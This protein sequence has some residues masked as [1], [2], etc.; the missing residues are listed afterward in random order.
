M[1][2]MFKT[3]YFDFTLDEVR[4]AA[5]ENRLLATEVEFNRV[6]NYRCPYCYADDGKGGCPT[7]DGVL[8]SEEI[9]SVIDQV[10]ALGAR[11]VVILG[12]EPLLYKGL[13]DK[14]AR[15]DRLGMRS[16]IFTNGALLTPELAATLF[17][18]RARVALKFNSLVPEVQEK[19]TGVR[20]ALDKC[21]RAIKLLRD[22]G[23]G[24]EPGLLAAS[25]VICSYNVDGMAGLWRWLR[26]EG[27]IPYF[28]IMTPQGRMLKNRHLHVDPLRLKEVFDEISRI[29][30]EEFD[31]E[32]EPQPPLVGGCCFRHHYSCL[33]NASGVVMPCVGVTIPL[34][35][36]REKPLKE[37]LFGSS[38][39]RDLKNYRETIKGPCRDCDK[40]DHCYGCRGAAYQM[41]GDHLASD[42]LC[43]R[44]AGKM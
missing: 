1:A 25:S 29:D 37:I 33:V 40:L 18:Y 3:G 7:D 31:R 41:T 38:V 26:N 5:A 17:K 35:S 13:E 14:L 39:I 43:W 12:G 2:D 36:V 32:W 6:C 27:M 22:A 20:G 28:E 11:K 44:N 34:G 4:A 30:R 9:D 42:P 8:T 19:M 10:A 15:I 23:Y 24:N 16:E 21:F